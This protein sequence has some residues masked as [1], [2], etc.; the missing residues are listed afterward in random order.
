MTVDVAKGKGYS[1]LTLPKGQE[2][3]FKGKGVSILSLAQ[4]KPSVRT[5][6]GYAILAR[7]ELSVPLVD[8]E[9]NRQANLSGLSWAWFNETDLDLMGGPL[10]TGD[11]AETDA[12]GVLNIIF[13][14]NIPNNT[15]TLFVQSTTTPLRAFAEVTQS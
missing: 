5:V 13:Q 7:L 9:G 4:E 6:R 12:N 15:G 11:N 8:R 14:F 10:E 3:V 2:V 1:V